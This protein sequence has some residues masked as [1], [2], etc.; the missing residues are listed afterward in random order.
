MLRT[1]CLLPLLAAAASAGSIGFLVDRPVDKLGKEGRA[2]LALA[3]TKHQAVVVTDR[4]GIDL[5][6]CTT[7]WYHQGDSADRSPLV[8]GPKPLAALR[9]YVEGGGRLFLT[10]AALAMVHDLKLE[11][12]QPRVGRA[13]NDNGAAGLR[14]VDRKHPIFAGLKFDGSQ[15]RLSDRGH[16]AY[17]DERGQHP[18]ALKRLSDLLAAV[19]CQLV[20]D[21]DV[22]HGFTPTGKPSFTTAFLENHPEQML[23]DIFTLR[24]ERKINEGQL[25]LRWCLK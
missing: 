13:G 14:P 17:A 6:G 3:Q 23:R 8:Y 10:G 15:A 24:I 1:L 9:A 18:L 16:P 7:V 20:F 5:E 25:L 11:T 4:T 2:A 22:V 19:L 12:A 21:F